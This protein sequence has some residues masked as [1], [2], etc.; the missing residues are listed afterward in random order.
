MKKYKL[1]KD[2][3][4]GGYYITKKLCDDFITSFNNQKDKARP[5][6]INSKKGARDTDKSRKDSLDLEVPCE[7]YSGIVGAYRLELQKCLNEY[8][9][10][11][12]QLNDLA[13][14]NVKENFNI[15]YYKPGGG[16]KKWH[17]ERTNLNATNR[18][19]VFMTYLNDV[20]DGGTEFKYQKIITPA[21]KGLTLIWPTDWPF[22]HRGQISKTKEKYIIT[23]WFNYY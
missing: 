10:T 13:K 23:G 7:L 3:F 15:Q 12:P 17:N 18:I 22:T 14:F 19:L 6:K 2:S 21:K 16:F 4:I 20:D 1:P 8:I 11:Y 9:K 5:G